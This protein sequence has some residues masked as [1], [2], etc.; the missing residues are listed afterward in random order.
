MKRSSLMMVA[1]LA[2]C[3]CAW[4]PAAVLTAQAA[5]GAIVF[6]FEGGNEHD[7]KVVEGTGKGFVTTKQ[8]VK[9]LQG[10][11]A[12]TTLY[13]KAGKSD[14]Y[15]MVIESP[16]FTLT[17][18]NVSFLVGGGRRPVT[19]VAICTTDGKEV[20]KAHLSLSA[21]EKDQI[22]KMNRRFLEQSL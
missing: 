20:F 18:G 2:G 17:K 15:R 19:Y 11:R 13:L 8:D 4:G 5:D 7:F 14:Q 16:V 1:V 9:E 22:Q 3:V 10:E 21:L 12:L 6:D